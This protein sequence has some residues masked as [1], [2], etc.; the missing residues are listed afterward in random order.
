[1]VLGL[2]CAKKIEEL[3][4]RKITF[5]SISGHGPIFYYTIKKNNVK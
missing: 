4:G 5:H 3:Q 2:Q 1:M